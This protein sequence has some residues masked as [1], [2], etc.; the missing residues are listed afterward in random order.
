MPPETRPQA[1]ALV[2]LLDV[3]RRLRA[4]C[5]WKAEQ[6]H[7]SLARYLLEETHETLEAI[8][9]GDAAHLREE[10]GDLLLQVY[11]HAVI[12][13]QSGAFDLD[14][15]ARGIT[16]KMVRRNPHVFAPAEPGSER[17]RPGDAA[18]VNE[19][20]EEIKAEEKSA[21]TSVLDGIAPTLPALLY[22][23]KALDRL[24][25]AGQ[26]VT[27]DPASPDLGERLLALVAE[28]RAAGI[29]PEQALRD[30]VREHT[31]GH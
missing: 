30:T 12:A 10:L 1:P 18:A 31:R 28:A 7:R 21:R 29:D 20:W 15:V 2:E 13:E 9:T 14:D 19:A 5:P 17:E 11:F 23:D 25:R 4:E 24:A 6:T 3:M 27:P 26:A 22:A 8:D 16:D